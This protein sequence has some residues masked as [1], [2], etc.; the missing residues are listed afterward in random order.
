MAP[1]FSPGIVLSTPQSLLVQDADVMP[2]DPRFSHGHDTLRQVRHKSWAGL[3]GPPGQ[4]SEIHGFSQNPHGGIIP[5]MVDVLIPKSRFDEICIL[6]A[7]LNAFLNV[8]FVT[9]GIL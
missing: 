2:Q 6:N 5:R 7:F 8:G 3:P 9:I 1:V 4:G